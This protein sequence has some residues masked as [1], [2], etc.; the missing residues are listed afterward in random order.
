MLSPNSSPGE[1]EK[2]IVRGFAA[3]DPNRQREIASRGG[4]AAHASG[5]AHVFSPAEAAAAGRKSRRGAVERQTLRSS[6]SSSP[7][8]T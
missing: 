8:Q 3:M 1:T 2:K 5:N 7:S 4:R 6:P